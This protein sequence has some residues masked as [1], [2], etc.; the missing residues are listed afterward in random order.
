MSLRRKKA[1]TDE[2]VSEHSI[3]FKQQTVTLTR[4]AVAVS[5]GDILPPQAQKRHSSYRSQL[6]SAGSLG[7][8]ITYADGMISFY[9][10]LQ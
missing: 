6:S 7:T 1:I 10:I 5:Q 2:N 3:Q 8:V 9:W 4:E